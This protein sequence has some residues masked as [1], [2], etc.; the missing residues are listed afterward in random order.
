MQPNGNYKT[1]VIELITALLMSRSFASL[2][3]GER[4]EDETRTNIS[5]FFLLTVLCSVGVGSNKNQRKKEEEVVDWWCGL[6]VRPLYIGWRVLSK[7]KRQTSSRPLVPLPVAA[8]CLLVERVETKSRR[9]RRRRRSDGGFVLMVGAQSDFSGNRADLSAS[10]S[11]PKFYRQLQ[12][13]WL[14]HQSEKTAPICGMVIEHWMLL[15]RTAHRAEPTD[16]ISNSIRRARKQSIDW[17]R[18]ARKKHNVNGLSNGL[19]RLLTEST[20]VAANQ[21]DFYVLSSFLASSILRFLKQR[22]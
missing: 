4:D 11:Q 21:I 3:W 1:V 9:K 16:W 10:F 18:M 7:R 20:R 12:I 5:T 14:W 15:H 22:W 19:F 13:E 17:T 8:A 6:R 2:L